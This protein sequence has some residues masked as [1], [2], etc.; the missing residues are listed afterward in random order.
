MKTKDGLWRL[1]PSSL[2]GYTECQ[3]CFWAD[4]HY[5]RAPMLP[6][7][8]NSAMDSI[9]KA[10]YDTYRA[11]GAFPPEAK[12]LAKEGI[13]PFVDLEQLN[14][15]RANTNA[16][17]IT[18][19]GAGYVLVGKIDD[20]LVE[21]DG[22]LVPTDYKSSG[23]APSIDKQKY[24]RDQLAAYGLMFSK[25]GHAVSNR[26]Y[27]LHYFVHDK[28]DP[29]I[30]VKFDSHVDRVEIDIAAIGQKLADMV[31]LLNGKYPGHNPECETC[32]YHG[33]RNGTLEGN[34]E[35]ELL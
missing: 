13:R 30:E 21:A 31:R 25:Y 24:Y 35:S 16:L 5:K 14:E 28:N 1:S 23:N 20:V 15:W 32:A 9:L 2:Y 34:V 4:N 29:S 22:R 11:D 33:G 6:L 10:R 18:D 7:L 8:L 17:K 19:E 12:E 3:S 26:A 27:L